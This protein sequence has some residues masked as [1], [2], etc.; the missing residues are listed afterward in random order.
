MIFYD[1][2][3]ALFHLQGPSYSYLMQVKDGVLMHLYWG[4]RLPDAQVD[5]LI[6]YPNEGASFDSAHSRRP[7]Q[8]PTQE[9]GY[10]GQ[11]ALN[12][13]N[14]EGDD[15]LSLRYQ[16]HRIFGGKKKLCGLPASYAEQECEAETL[17]IDLKDELTGVKA[18]LSFAV[19]AEY[20][21][22][23]RSMTVANEGEKPFELTDAQSAVRLP[24]DEYEVLHL[25][26]A[27]G[28]ERMAK[29]VPMAEGHFA[30]KSRRGAS[31]HENNP[32][33][34][35]V[36][37]HT[38]EDQGDVYAMTHV[39][40][41]SFCASV[42][43][44]IDAAPAMMIG[45]CSDVFQWHMEP[46]D[47]FQC[48]EA[49]FVYAPDGLNGLSRR[50]HPF[51]RRRIC[52]GAWRDQP[53]PIL[54]NNWE[55]TYFDFNFDKLIA[56]AK[57]G[58]EIGCELFV[59]DD[60]WFGKRN[61]DNCSLGDWVVNEEKLSG[62]IRRIAEAVNELGLRF[63]LWFEPEMISPDSDLYRA[64]PDWALHIEGRDYI[65]SRHQLTLDL[66]RQDVQDFIVDAVTE[67][68]K[69]SGAS[70]LKW[71]MNR[72]FSNIGSSALPA[73][74]QKEVPHRY[75]LG[76]YAVM[77]RL[78]KAFPDVLFEGCS[79]GGGRFDAGLLYYV[80]Q[81]WC[82]DNTDALCRCQIQYGTTLV[83]PA[84]TMGS[85]VSAVPNHQTGRVTPLES[86]FAVAMGGAFGYEL[87]PRKLSDE[88]RKQLRGQ[89]DY[90]ARTQE[91][92]L[93]GDFY[94]L[95]SPFE[96]NDTAWMSVSKDRSEAI[97]TFVRALAQPNAMPPLVRMRGLDPAKRYRVEETGEVYGGDELMQVGLCCRLHP[98]GSGDAASLL[99]TLKAVDEA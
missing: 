63:G 75:I 90:A 57:R 56:I 64:H 22:L 7:V 14:P 99:Y 35:L 16:D 79:S 84:S 54:V 86:R 27:W 5:G 40:S 15:V 26:G 13:R 28:R 24:L 97:F 73:N 42:D 70:Y 3:T 95:L 44:G 38:T 25:K 67:T 74:R 50:M 43:V 72:H 77:E 47:V 52:R 8:V 81:Y 91:L 32:F 11:R 21:V 62:G 78:V 71:D 18:T 9:K 4:G 89:I 39:Y 37:P 45:L 17:E 41:G 29:R 59:L 87:D 88:D 19:F 80:P 53:R 30:I 58:A 76:L 33:L 36:K 2:K 10:F 94:R 46:G 83:F 1:S 85:H 23:A 82:S 65:T 48:P 66:G 61:T 34:A 96:G 98:F 55:A 69:D 31:G 49:L 68:L 12:V 92:R 20:D 51:I 60:G 93:Y 6:F